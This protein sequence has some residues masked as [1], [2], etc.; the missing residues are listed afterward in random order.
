METNLE[1]TADSVKLTVAINKKDL[2]AENFNLENMQKDIEKIKSTARILKTLQTLNDI[3]RDNDPHRKATFY[4][5]NYV[6][7]RVLS[8]EVPLNVFHL[9]EGLTETFGTYHRIY[10][11]LCNK[12]NIEPDDF[13]FDF[14]DLDFCDFCSKYKKEEQ[15]T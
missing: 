9:I 4:N 14:G 1:Q 8:D 2:K 15:T 7:I 13:D 10:S 11:D 12:Y 6:Y 5:D 3:F